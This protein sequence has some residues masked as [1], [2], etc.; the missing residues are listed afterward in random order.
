MEDAMDDVARM[1]IVR[2][3]SE[4]GLPVRKPSA[5]PDVN[6][7]RRERVRRAARAEAAVSARITLRGRIGARR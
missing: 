1:Q 4:I 3:R 2:V 7:R 6:D 5:Q